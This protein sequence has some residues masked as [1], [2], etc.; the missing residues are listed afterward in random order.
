MILLEDLYSKSLRPARVKVELSV[1]AGVILNGHLLNSL[2]FADD[3]DSVA[4]P[5][6]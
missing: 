4:E 5:P 6:Y 1:E 3:T 2:H